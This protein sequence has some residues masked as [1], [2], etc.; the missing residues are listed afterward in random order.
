[1]V[2]I[3]AIVILLGILVGVNR[4]SSPPVMPFGTLHL[5]AYTHFDDSLTGRRRS[6]T[7]PLRGNTRFVS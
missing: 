3:S 5:I 2:I 1:M 4:L 7:I 6:D